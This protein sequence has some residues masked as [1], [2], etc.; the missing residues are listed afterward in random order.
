MSA[1]CVN[2]AWRERGENGPLKWVGPSQAGLLECLPLWFPGER[3]WKTNGVWL[4]YFLKVLEVTCCRCGTGAGA[5]MF[6]ACLPSCPVVCQPD[7]MKRAPQPSLLPHSCSI[8]ARDHSTACSMALPTTRSACSHGS[9][10]VSNWSVEVGRHWLMWL[11]CRW[12]L[13]V[14]SPC[15]GHTEHAC[16]KKNARSWGIKQIFAEK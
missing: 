16:T 5:L 6:A 9:D 12:W 4:P 2:K 1:W 10:L 7:T 15:C 11:Y 3:R 13:I 14:C 8:S